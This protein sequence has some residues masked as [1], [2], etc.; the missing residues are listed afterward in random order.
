MFTTEQNCQ[1]D[2][3]LPLPFRL[4]GNGSKPWESVLPATPSQARQAHRSQEGQGLPNQARTWAQGLCGVC[5]PGIACPCVRAGAS[6][7]TIS[8]F[9]DR[10][11]PVTRVVESSEKP[12][13]ASVTCRAAHNS[14]C[15]PAHHAFTN[16]LNLDNLAKSCIGIAT[17]FFKRTLF[18]VVVPESQLDIDQHTL[19]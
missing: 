9:S 1:N 7:S 4:S 12:R 8:P 6:L 3:G 17:Y 19:Q 16:P 10:T 2:P 15:F 5:C 14:A 13:N 18:S 11:L